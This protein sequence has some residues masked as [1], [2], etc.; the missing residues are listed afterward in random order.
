MDKEIIS[1]KLAKNSLGF[2][3]NISIEL[4]KEILFGIA[5]YV[6]YFYGKFMIKSLK[7]IIFIFYFNNAIFKNDLKDNLIN[8]TKIFINL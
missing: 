1:I 8:R 5:K 3:V 6:K 2:F 7:D 4:R